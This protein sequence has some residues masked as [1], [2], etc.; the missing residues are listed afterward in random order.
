MKPL[1]QQIIDKIKKSRGKL[2]GLKADLEASRHLYNPQKCTP[3]RAS[4]SP[5]TTLH[6][7]KSCVFVQATQYIW[8]IHHNQLLDIQTQLQK[9][10]QDTF[11]CYSQP[12]NLLCDLGVPPLQY[13][14][15][16]EFTRLHYRLFN[17]PKSSLLNSIHVSTEQLSPTCSLWPGILCRSDRQNNISPM[18]TTLTA[19]PAPLPAPDYATESRKTFR[20][21]TPQ[22]SV[23]HLAQR[24]SSPP[25][26]SVH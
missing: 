16:K 18:E 11:D 17:K 22:S 24:N 8:Y 19:S 15:H 23:R 21:I 9:S 14:R 25:H 6:L 1:Q 2:Q 20:T 12:F 26:S 5:M 10:I 7:W 4:T 3:G 13:F